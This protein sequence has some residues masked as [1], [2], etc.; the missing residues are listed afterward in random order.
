MKHQ[1]QVTT[2]MQTILNEEEFAYIK[3]KREIRIDN[4]PWKS[5]WKVVP[6]EMKE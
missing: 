5:W 1:I 4:L 3:Y 2:G 6:K